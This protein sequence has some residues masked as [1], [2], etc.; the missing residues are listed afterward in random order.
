[1]PCFFVIDVG[2]HFFPTP[3]TKEGATIADVFISDY[4][5]IATEDCIMNLSRRFAMMH[6]YKEN[7]FPLLQRKMM[8]R[9]HSRKKVA[10][11]R[12]KVEN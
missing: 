9:R 10:E 11:K 8:T 5:T 4:I 7:N 12:R 6:M 2:A 1:M 3:S